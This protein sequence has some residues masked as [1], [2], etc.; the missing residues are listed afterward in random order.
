[1][2][3]RSEDFSLRTK[4]PNSAIFSNSSGGG[5]DPK[6]PVFTAPAG[7][8][9]RFRVL[10]PGADTNPTVVFELHGHSWR[11]E[12]FVDRSRKLGD[13]AKS[14]VFGSQML[15]PH[16]GLNLL[17]D[18][19]GGPDGTPGDYL[20]SNYLARGSGTGAWGILRVVPEKEK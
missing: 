17:I 16:Q 10:M 18:R 4:P 9:V 15:V 3:N 20:F 8:P 13:N 14:Q 6:T 5:A 19:A 11:E 7:K 1:V 12:P 2:N